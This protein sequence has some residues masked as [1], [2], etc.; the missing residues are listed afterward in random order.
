MFTGF[1]VFIIFN[2]E[3]FLY[4]LF[5]QTNST[6]YIGETHNL[7]ERLLKHNNHHYTGNFTRIANDWGVVLDFKC[8]SKDEAIY[9]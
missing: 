7:N 5:S 2:M 9:L 6:Y 3:H 4:I 8:K 1:F